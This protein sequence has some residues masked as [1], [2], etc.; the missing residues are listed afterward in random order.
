MSQQLRLD[1]VRSVLA[2]LEETL[3]FGFIERAQFR[4]N[5]VIYQPGALGPALGEE[6]LV[7][8]LLHETERIHARLRRYTSP[9]EQPFFADLPPPILSALRFHDNPLAPNTVNIND[10]IRTAYECEIV[11]FLC[12]PGDDGQYGS[13]AVCDITSLQA[14]SK[15]IHYGKFVAESKFRE[16][17]ETY[18]ALARAGDAA[19]V[20]ARIL[21][22][23]VEAAVL[24]RI[25]RKARSYGVEIGAPES[26]LD[27]GV[28]VEIYRRWIIPMN[29]AVQVAYLLARGLGAP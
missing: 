29:K 12:E 19:T 2:R 8:H 13:S 3:L 1:H 5:A 23:E 22:P 7:S 27:P 11:P 4:V 10:R 18:S 16:Q 24:R 25:E 15:R 20:A 9:D 6:S 21:D 17:P 14:V 26:A 28:F